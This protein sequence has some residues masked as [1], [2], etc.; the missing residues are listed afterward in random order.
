MAA[1]DWAGRVVIGVLVYFFV[2]FIIYASV[3]NLAASSVHNNPNISLST[4]NVAGAYGIGNSTGLCSDPR[5]FVNSQGIKQQY[6]L[7]TSSLDCNQ[8]YAFN[9]TQCESVPDCSWQVVTEGFWW[10]QT[11]NVTCTGNINDTYLSLGNTSYRAYS[12][13]FL[14]TYFQRENSFGRWGGVSV[15]ESPR[16]QE[17]QDTCESL[18]CTWTNPQQL[19]P[20]QTPSIS[21]IIKGMFGFNTSLIGVPQTINVIMAF[22]NFMMIMLLILAGAAYVRG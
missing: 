12:G 11:A 6:A 3:S 9:Q 21:N 7:S 8:L 1:A 20:A 13:L 22:I 5:Y 16:A 10:W 17:G 14:G 2:I 19:N 4:T 18:G 15:C